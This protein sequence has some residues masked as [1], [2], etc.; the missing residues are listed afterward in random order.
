M[1]FDCVNG[2]GIVQVGK[3]SGAERKRARERTAVEETVEKT[4]YSNCTISGDQP[5][6]QV[7]L[8]VSEY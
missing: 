2:G 5:A 3:Y 8:L 7:L 4:A 1:V 6:K